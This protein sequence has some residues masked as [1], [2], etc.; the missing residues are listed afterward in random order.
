[1]PIECIC[2]HSIFYEN[3]LNRLNIQIIFLYVGKNKCITT[4]NSRIARESD[5]H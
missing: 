1:M 3:W 5:A 4:Q 2:K